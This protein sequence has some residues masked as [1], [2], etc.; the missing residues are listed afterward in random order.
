[1]QFHCMLA[2]WAPVVDW[3]LTTMVRYWIATSNPLLDYMLRAM[4]PAGSSGIPIRV[5]GPPWGQAWQ[6]HMPP[7]ATLLLYW[8]RLLC[9]GKAWQRIGAARR[10]LSPLAHIIP[11]RM[12]Q[13]RSTQQ[14]W[15][16]PF[17]GTNLPVGP[18]AALLHLVLLIVL[19]AGLVTYVPSATAAPAMSVDDELASFV[20]EYRKTQGLP[21][22]SYTVLDDGE[23][24]A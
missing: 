5:A 24:T 23:V 19:V 13:P 15:A 9:A 18:P 20:D 2:P 16:G 17:S 8:R 6:E 1:M 11:A 12:L 4:F 14:P 21:G 10:R 22:I 7:Q 3:R